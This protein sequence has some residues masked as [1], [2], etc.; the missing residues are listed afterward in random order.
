MRDHGLP[1]TGQQGQCAKCGSC[2]AVCPVYRV[3]GRESLTARGRLHLLGTELAARPSAAYEDLF[4]QCLLCGACEN[5][6]PRHLPIRR[7]TVEA[8]SRFSFLYGRHPLRRSLVRTVLA[9]P[10]LLERLVKTGLALE[11]LPLIPRDSGLRL[12]L[13][14]LDGE[15]AAGPAAQQETAIEPDTAAAGIQYFVGCLARY[16]Q[17]S[18]AGATR[19]LVRRFSGSPTVEPRAQGCCG[20]AAWS[21]GDREEAVRLAKQNIEAFESST[22][23]VLTSCVSCFAHLKKYGELFSDDPGWRERAEWFSRRVREFS[24]FMLELDPAPVFRSPG[25]ERIL[26]HEPCHLRFSGENREAPPALLRQLQGAVIVEPEGGPH[27]CGQ[28]GLFS[29]GYPELGDRIFSRACEA[30]LATGADVL[31]T[32]CS[33]CLLQWRTGLDIRHAPV[34]VLHPAVLLADCLDNDS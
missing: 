20:L 34:R 26:Y 3:T 25:R 13:A 5:V 1:L 33:G 16:L 8:R 12:K 27:C 6:C 32:G 11:R 30:A 15:P 24:A 4:A 29:L 23:P 18:I 9:R 31:A 7:L 21:A 22:G 28:G 19:R 14:L 17:P 10:V 2:T